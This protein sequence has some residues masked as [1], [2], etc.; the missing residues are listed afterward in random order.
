MRLASL[1]RDLPNPIESPELLEFLA[2]AQGHI[3]PDSPGLFVE[4]FIVEQRLL[5]PLPVL[6]QK[7]WGVATCLIRISGLI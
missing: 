6:L 2:L 5:Q 3:P 7:T 1:E 4:H